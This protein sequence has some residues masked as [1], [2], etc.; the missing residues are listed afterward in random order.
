VTPKNFV[1]I[2]ADAVPNRHAALHGYCVYDNAQSSLNALIM[3]DYMLHLFD[4]LDTPAVLRL[5]EA[6]SRSIKV[7]GLVEGSSDGKAQ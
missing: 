3:A 7:T 6:A 2:S 5:A 4:Q 1:D